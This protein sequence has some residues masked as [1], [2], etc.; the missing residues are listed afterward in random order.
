MANQKTIEQKYKKLTDVEHALLR[1]ARY[2]GAISPHTATT[3]VYSDADGKMVKQEVTWNPGLIKLFDE[4]IS[5]SV[6]F[7]K[8]PEGK[9]L[10]TIKVELDQRTGEMSVFDNGGI[11]VQMHAEYKEYV[12]TLIFGY[13]RS[14]SNF[15]DADDSDGTGQNGEGSSL[16][17]IFSTKFTVETCDGKK[18]FKQTWTNNMMKKSSPAI[19]DMDDKGYTKITWIPDYEHLGTTLDAGNYL[20]LVKRVHDVAGCNPKLKVY[21]NGSRIKIDSF[22]DYIALYGTDFEYDDGGDWQVGIARSDEGFKHVSFV[23]STETWNGGTHVEYVAEQVVDGLR[24]H[25]KAKFKQD[26]K[27]SELKS[28]LMLFINARIIKPRYNSQTKDCLITEPK[29]YKTAYKLSDKVLARLLKSEI[30]ESILEWLEAKAKAQEIMDLKKA[31]K[32]VDKTNPRRI[33]KLDDAA[34][35]GK[36]PEECYLFICEGDSA[37]KAILSGR[38]PRTMGSLAFRGKPQNANSVSLK[39]LL[40]RKNEKTG[41]DEPTEFF[42][43]MTAMG[44]KI[45]VKVKSVKDLRYARLVI[46]SDADQDGGHIAGLMVSNIHKFWPELFTLGVVYRFFTPIVKVWLKGK[47]KDEPL[48]FET[49]VEYHA[50]MATP[51]NAESVKAYKYYKG[52]GTSEAEDFKGYLSNVQRHLVRIDL[53]DAVNEGKLINLVFGKEEGSTDKRKDW[54]DISEDPIFPLKAAA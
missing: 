15:D 54:L 42:N 21:L 1:P 48:A 6:D 19:I 26:V 39:R 24:S 13:L 36:K 16:T 41:Q 2:I 4:I 52:L 9:H 8:T 33:L 14:G 30:I 27:P 43:M 32:D 29:E 18:R 25:L 37:A 10:D 31:G 7:S 23:N 49:E 46:T 45:D 38:D 35:A 40:Y 47:K 34:L 22:K 11:P 20:K 50:W 17:N 44:L 53:A 12:P 3:W 51:G 28:H 5:N